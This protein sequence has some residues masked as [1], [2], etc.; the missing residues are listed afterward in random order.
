MDLQARIELWKSIDPDP[1][2]CRRAEREMLL[3]S[4]ADEDW[5]SARMRD[6]EEALAPETAT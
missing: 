1:E 2:F 5:I 6:F 4:C 3:L